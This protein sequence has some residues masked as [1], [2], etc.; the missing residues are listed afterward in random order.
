MARGL[1]Y[2]TYLNDTMKEKPLFYWLDMVPTMMWESLVFL[3]RANFGGLNREEEENEDKDEQETIQ[4]YCFSP[5][6]LQFSFILTIALGSFTVE[7]FGL[8]S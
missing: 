6:H 2:W 4:V 1:A 3:D 5:F 8:S 7:H